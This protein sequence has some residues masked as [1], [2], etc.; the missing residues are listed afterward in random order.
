[1]RFAFN[2]YRHWEKLILRQTGEPPVTIL[3]REGVAQVDSLS[4]V[5]YRIILVPLAKELIAA[6]PGILSPLHADDVSFDGL[7][8]QSAQLL[9]LSMKRGTDR[10]YFPDLYKSLF[11]SDVPGQE[12]AARR[13]FAAEVLSLNYVSGSRY[14]G[15][16][17]GL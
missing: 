15:A 7:A 14:L 5:L 13:E 17:L 3:I 4:V 10:G 6:D 8:R 2:C 11:I 16:Y 12:E 1:M 9:K